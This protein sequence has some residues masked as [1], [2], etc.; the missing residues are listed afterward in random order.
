MTN[1]VFKKNTHTH[2]MCVLVWVSCARNVN[3]AC[4]QIVH[5]YFN[6]FLSNYSSRKDLSTLRNKLHIFF[7]R[8][9]PESL[10][11]IQK[12]ES[13]IFCFRHFHG[14]IKCV[15]LNQE[16]AMISINIYMRI[17]TILYECVCLLW[18]HQQGKHNTAPLSISNE[19]H[20]DI[21]TSSHFE[22]CAPFIFQRESSVN[23]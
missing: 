3:D 15:C 20:A 16:N 7:N 12:F 1:S 4:F 9:W 11:C 17:Y 18:W 13:N 5:R 6:S 8:S 10:F 14:A 19:T 23:I 2:S 22:R 21:R